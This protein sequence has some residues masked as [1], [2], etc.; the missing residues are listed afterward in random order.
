MTKERKIK[1]SKKDFWKHAAIPESGVATISDGNIKILYDVSLEDILNAQK[2]RLHNEQA[3]QLIEDIHNQMTGLLKN[4]LSV[5]FFD[6]EDIVVIDGHFYFIND[7]RIL[8]TED[9]DMTIIEIYRDGMFKPHK[10]NPKDNSSIELPVVLH[11][12]AYMYSLALLT[13]YCVF[14]MRVDTR[15]KA[16][17]VLEQLRG[18]VLYWCLH[19]CLSLN[20]KERCVLMI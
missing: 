11:E 9:Q 12:N 8:K 17:K 16:L 4:R 7:K 10:L 20:E 13:L 3:L 15:E 18:T 2:Q 6:I 19:R 1:I 14:H 5:P